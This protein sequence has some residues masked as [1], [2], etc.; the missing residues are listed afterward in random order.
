MSRLAGLRVVVA[1]AGA[2]GSV[3]AFTLQG[4]G[5]RVILCD[6]AA[7]AD[8]ASGVAAGM[9]APAFEAVLDSASHDHFP[10]LKAARDL[11][12]DLAA[13]CGASLDRSGA[14]W[15]G[16]EA[17]QARILGGLHAIGAGAET[18][19]A[20]AVEGAWPWLRAPC[21]AVA[22]WEDWRIEP[23]A[24]LAGLR[25]GFLA[26]GGEM[27]A[28]ALRTTAAT[29]ITVLATGLAPRDM[30]VSIV[31]LDRLSPV[32]GQIA[33]FPGTGPFAGP[34][35]RAAGVYVAPSAAGA[36]VG[37]TMEVGFSDR[38]VDPAALQ[39]LRDLAAPLVPALA[40]GSL[41]GEAGV[42]AA[43][44]D[45]LPLVGASSDPAVFLALGARRNGW[46]LAPLI[47]QVVADRLAGDEPG[48]W[49]AMLDAGRFEVSRPG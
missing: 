17:G 20:S 2:V 3:L 32:K 13:A 26:R 28:E 44:P 9:L 19:G 24:M 39:R 29:D 18:L 14:L 1:G 33:R 16:D 30:A 10:I 5:A 46:L 42:R 36:A 45:G 34:A 38:A 37:A 48:P 22:T 4:E 25:A 40:R 43:T 15:V 23:L 49:A 41:V 8:N 47:A 6:P 11:W 21:G 12:P 27:R 7:P 31:A 35:V